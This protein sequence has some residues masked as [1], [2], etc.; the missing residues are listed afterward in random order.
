MMSYLAIF[1][2]VYYILYFKM[3]INVDLAQLT[4]TYPVPIYVLIYVH[5]R[6][7]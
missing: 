2:D 4:S 7:I 1:N 3:V 6:L 5:G